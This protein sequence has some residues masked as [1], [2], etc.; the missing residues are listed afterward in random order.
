MVKSPLGIYGY[1]LT[2]LII[3]NRGSAIMMYEE[4][5]KMLVRPSGRI[6][7]V[8]DSDAYNEVDDQFAIAYMLLSE[9]KLNVRAIY[10]AP[11]SNRRAKAP[12]DGMKLSYNEIIKVAGMCTSRREGVRVLHGSECYLPS[13]SEPVM[14]DAAL[15]MVSLS[16]SYSSEKP[17]YIVAIGAI[18]NVASALLIDPSMRERVVVVWLGGHAIGYPDTKEFNMYQDIA[19]ARVLFSSGVP[20]VLLP[21]NGV[22]EAM[23][24]TRPELDFWLSG[25]NALCDYLIESVTREASSCSKSRAWSRTIWDVAAVA[26]LL[27]D[28]GSMMRDRIISAPMPEYDHTYSYPEDAHPIRYV[29]HINRDAIFDDM[30][31]KLTKL[32]Y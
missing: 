27:N 25:K 22:V 11:F 30:F 21:C 14:S 20:L 18:T 17:L 10:A 3:K 28:D 2:G 16:H 7:V 6:D 5:K 13:E 19:G 4:I 15:D 1:L 23:K 24:T 29:Y 8:L 32:S 26:W 31:T 9:E 12:G